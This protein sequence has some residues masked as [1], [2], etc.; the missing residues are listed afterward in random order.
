MLLSYRET[1]LTDFTK[2]DHARCLEVMNQNVGCSVNLD[3]CDPQ[4]EI[5]H[6]CIYLDEDSHYYAPAGTPDPRNLYNRLKR[7]LRVKKL[8]LA[9]YPPERGE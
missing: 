1:R 8:C 6:V 4:G 7:R 3:V 2:D 9:I 5:G